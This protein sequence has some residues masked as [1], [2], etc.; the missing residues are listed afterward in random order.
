MFVTI[1]SELTFQYKPG[2]VFQPEVLMEQI[3]PIAHDPISNQEIAYVSEK[4]LID[5]LRYRSF[6][7]DEF[8]SS[9]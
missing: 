5:N 4:K 8:M 1:V 9:V 7:K 2:M 3:F 6:K